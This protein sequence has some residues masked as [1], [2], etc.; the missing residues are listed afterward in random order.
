MG[1]ARVKQPKETQTSLCLNAPAALVNS[2]KSDA[3]D[4]RVFNTYN[5]SLHIKCQ[6][7]AILPCRHAK[8]L[9]KQ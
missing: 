1:Q 6:F 3:T 7:F 9:L 2:A 8:L 5:T 4:S